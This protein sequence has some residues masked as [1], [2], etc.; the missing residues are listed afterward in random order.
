MGGRDSKGALI[1][2]DE[3]DWIRLEIRLRV[4]I[5]YYIRDHSRDQI[6]V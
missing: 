3:I 5:R 4:E 6:I 2:L 1:R